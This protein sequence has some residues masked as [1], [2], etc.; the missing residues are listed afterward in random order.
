MH[1]SYI[2]YDDLLFSS[3][4]LQYTENYATPDLQKKNSAPSLI[5]QV[6]YSEY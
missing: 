4:L 2:I 5:S 6:L 3:P 1:M